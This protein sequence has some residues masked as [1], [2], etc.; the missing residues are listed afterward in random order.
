[1]S[2]VR[3]I[4]ALKFFNQK[5]TQTKQSWKSQ[6]YRCIVNEELNIFPPFSTICNVIA[7]NLEKVEAEMHTQP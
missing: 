5:K 1:M 3:K 6:Q 7:Y 4:T 2:C